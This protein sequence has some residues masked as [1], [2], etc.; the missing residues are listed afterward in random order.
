MRA[1]LALGA[2][3]LVGL[4][5]AGSR[6]SF[7]ADVTHFLPEGD[8]GTASA[9]SR[10]LAGSELPRAMVLSLRG[11]VGAEVR[12]AA[13]DLAGRLR[14]LPE[15]AWARAGPDPD[16]PAA[17][18]RIYFPRRH[19][20]LSDGSGPNEPPPAELW[21]ED[22]LRASARRT[23]QQLAMP[24]GGARAGLLARD[25]L[26]AMAR[27]VARARGTDPGLRLVDGQYAGR[28]GADALVL[29][30][31]RPS[32]FE[33]G[34]QAPLLGE[35]DAAIE[36]T[37]S[38]W[39]AA[40]LHVEVSGVNRFAVRVEERMRG[41]AAAML[42][43]S[44]LG[45]AG[46][47]LLFFRRPLF[48]VLAVLPPVAGVVGATCLALLVF[49][50][51]DLLTLVFGASLVGVAID[52]AI[53]LV[54]HQMLAPAGTA[55]SE[56]ARRL[57]PSLLLGAGTTVASFAGLLLTDFPG[58]REMGFFGIAGIAT[59]LAVTLGVLP[60]MLG[61]AR[62]D[63]TAVPATAEGLARAVRLLA[64][65]RSRWLAVPLLALV[66]AGIQAPSLR[67]GDDLRGLSD[68]DPELVA[69]DARVRAELSSFDTSRL[70]LLEAADEASLLTG[71]DR[72]HR[73][74]EELVAAGA[75]AGQRS[76]H[77]L[78]WAPGLQLENRR[79]WQDPDAAS[80][81]RLAF[82][83]EGLRPDAFEPFLGDLRAAAPP[84]LTLSD[85]R[86]SPFAPLVESAVL[87]AGEGLL[88]VT[89]LRG[90]RDLAAVEA[91]LDRVE[92]ARLFDQTALIDRSFGAFRATTLRQI[93][94]G[95]L[96]VLAVLGLRYRRA[97]PALAAFLP[98][99]TTALLL[100]G[101]F[102]ALDVEVNLLHA[103]SLLLVLGMGVDYGIFLV[104]S[105][106]DRSHLGPTLL[107]LLASCLTT[108]F[109]F[110]AL[111]LS[112]H[113]ALRAIGVTTGLGVALCFVLAPVTWA[114]LHGAPRE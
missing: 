106:G 30:Q 1:G 112:S 93:G 90:V 12:R 55:A 20:F 81:F 51:L 46:L 36:A 44:L 32:A 108:I 39:P 95:S 43:V 105:A 19:D 13:K 67:F 98:A 97:R 60:R 2:A 65:H 26:G 42:A 47:F 58:F 62:A 99:A 34:R 25:P 84:P 73:E 104:D 15:V 4:W 41:E 68:I 63:R 92:G 78:L 31:T 77:A 40:E 71:T 114:A 49:G 85:L 89:Y 110:G 103:V 10:V 21:S 91:R 17:L 88:A 6:M 24:G 72:L 54:N 14:A 86:A 75:L 102:A 96:F 100:L 5:F 22:A 80:R 111:A 9:V 64:R 101:G 38:A 69:E 8:A 53:H 23:R 79:A 109:V 82:A 70:V 3:L 56:T 87:D 61:T 113:P 52:Y 18:E 66:L 107:S 16:L 83:A 45:V 50:D 57:R 11:R 27:I 35:I 59:A 33:T 74:L 76:L 7:R 28:A 48:L 37:R 94:V 29:L